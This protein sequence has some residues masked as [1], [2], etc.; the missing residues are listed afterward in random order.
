VLID[1]HRLGDV[2]YALISNSLDYRQ[3]GLSP[4]IAITCALHPNAAEFS[5]TDNGIG[6]PP[7]Y[8]SRV[9]RVFERL[10]PHQGSD[11]TGIGLAIVRSIVE[12]V[13]GRIWITTPEEGGT[14]ITF[15]LPTDHPPAPDEA[16]LSG[17]ALPPGQKP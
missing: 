2:F 4:R 7:Q 16:K 10:N 5:V 15:T 11:G 17:P 8:H 6:I 12:S 9:F 3:P 13:Q 14:R 1:S